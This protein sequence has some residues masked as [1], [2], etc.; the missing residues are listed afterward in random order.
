MVALV[1]ASHFGPSWLISPGWISHS[2][3]SSDARVLEMSNIEVL[4]TTVSFSRR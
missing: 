3:L 2:L 1:F 4:V